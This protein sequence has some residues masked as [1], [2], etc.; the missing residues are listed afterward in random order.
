MTV[1]TPGT[2]TDQQPTRFH[3]MI[4]TW[5]GSSVRIFAARYQDWQTVLDVLIIQSRTGYE[6]GKD[7]QALGVRE[8]VAFW[9]AIKMCRCEPKR[10]TQKF[11]V[12]RYACPPTRKSFQID[13]QEGLSHYLTLPSSLTPV[14]SIPQR[15]DPG[16]ARPVI[17]IN[18][19]VPNPP[20]A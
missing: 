6:T 15:I 20:L 17:C 19:P 9:W 3:Q 1:C 12:A 11:E 2:P 4:L 18:H 16:T 10:G 13:P 7:S 5:V 8:T 14:L